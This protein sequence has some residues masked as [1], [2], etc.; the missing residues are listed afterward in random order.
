MVIKK[1]H[2]TKKKGSAEDYGQEDF[3]LSLA[4]F[5]ILQYPFINNYIVS[6]FGSS[7][8]LFSAIKGAELIII[9][10]GLAVSALSTPLFLIATY[11]IVGVSFF[12]TVLLFPDNI[13]IIKLIS[14]DVIFFS[15]S[16]IICANALTRFE[17]LWT[18]YS[19]SSPILLLMGLH[20]I[21][22]TYESFLYDMTLGY[23]MLIPS[24]VSLY[25]SFNKKRSIIHTISFL[26]GTVEIIMRGSRGPAFIITLYLFLCIYLYLFPEENVRNSANLKL[27]LG[28]KKMLL[29][30]TGIGVVVYLYFN[31]KTVARVLFVSLN[32]MGIYVRTLGY[33][34]DGE[35]F[36]YVSGRDDIYSIAFKLIRENPFLGYG[37]GGDCVNIG[38][39]YSAMTSNWVGLYAHNLLLG[40]MIHF[41]VFVGILLF[42]AFVLGIFQFIKVEGVRSKE[43]ALFLLFAVSGLSMSM[44]TGT[45]LTTPLLWCIAGMLFWKRKTTRNENT[46]TYLG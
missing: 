26:L 14:K 10:A 33:I 36:S 8:L 15:C 37:I 27:S 17:S 19:K 22:R 34:A 11:F 1:K 18:I 43:G 6:L 29:S 25:N 7:S 21:F 5:A 41:G 46:N 24:M 44:V 2:L 38:S 30:M 40:L 39:H 23:Q 9:I 4:L 12:L 32:S 42:A 3:I 16:A 31:I 28:M 35:A 45:Y 13:V 20:Y